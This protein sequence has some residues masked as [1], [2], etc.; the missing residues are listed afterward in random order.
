MIDRIPCCIPG[1]GRTFKREADDVG[2]VTV[3]CG[4]HWRMGDEALRRR[5]KQLR[6]RCRWFERKWKFRHKAIDALPPR[7]Q[8]VSRRMAPC[9]FGRSLRV[10]A[11]SERCRDKSGARRRRCTTPAA[12]GRRMTRRILNNR[13]HHEVLE[14]RFWNVDFT[15]G[16]GRDAREGSSVEPIQELFINAGKTGV[17]METLA[18]DSAVLLSIAL[19]YGAPIEI[20]RR[21]ITRNVDGSPSGP[22]GHLL[23]LLGGGEVSS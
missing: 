11:S 3:M 16:V 2:D 6:K 22:I 4:R 18:R 10:A 21:A 13:R 20:M 1:C 5:H 14:F 15:V 12:E 7:A 17:Q 8:E 23:D 9:C 19:Q